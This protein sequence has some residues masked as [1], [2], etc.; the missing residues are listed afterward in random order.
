MWN[1]CGG[2][3]IDLGNRSTARQI[4]AARRPAG[5]HSVILGIAEDIKIADAV[6]SQP[7]LIEATEWARQESIGGGFVVLVHSSK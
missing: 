3:K 1:S 5:I 7:W 2:W 4:V 6:A